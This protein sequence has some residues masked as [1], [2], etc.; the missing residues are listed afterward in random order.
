MLLSVIIPAHNEEDCIY[1]TV[2][3]LCDTLTEAVI[4]FEIL[5]INDHSTD[6]TELVLGEL[7]RTYPEVRWVNNRQQGGFGFAIR[8]GLDNFSGD[9]VCIVMADASDDPADVVKYYRK[10]QE[11]YECV[12]GSRFTPSSRVVDYP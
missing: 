1:S 12:F 2:T 3:A 4:P 11:G 9:A 8:T 10:L 7:A 6:G 5:V